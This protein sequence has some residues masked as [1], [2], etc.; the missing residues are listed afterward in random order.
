MFYPEEEHKPRTAHHVEEFAK[1]A[2][3]S[4]MAGCGIKGAS[5][6]SSHINITDSVAIDYMHAVLEGIT[7]TLLST[8]LDSKYHNS[9][10]YLGTSSITEEIDK[11]LYQIK[12]PQEF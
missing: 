10:F 11:Q 5:V 8:C 4:G 7:R 1:A 12:L 3:E 9:R 2:E 6:L